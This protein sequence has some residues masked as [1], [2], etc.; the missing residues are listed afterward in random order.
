M[1]RRTPRSTRT[2]TLFPHTTL[3]RSARP[4]DRAIGGEA[5]LDLL[6]Q[7]EGDVRARQ[8]IIIAALGAVDEQLAVR[9]GVDAIAVA[10]RV[11]RDQIGLA[12]ADR[13]NVGLDPAQA[14]I[15]AERRWEKSLLGEE[16]DSKSR[17]RWSPYTKKKKN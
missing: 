13:G 6:R 3:F 17:S 7:V 9:I 16:C 12:I 2:D 5:Q 14:D 10:G 1:K 15:A 4:R 11:D 8:E